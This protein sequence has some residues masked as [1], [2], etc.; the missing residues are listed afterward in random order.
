VRAQPTETSA[1]E[2]W[3]QE[4]HC[5]RPG[6]VSAASALHLV[7]ALGRVHTLGWSRSGIFWTLCYALLRST[8]CRAALAWARASNFNRMRPLNL[9]SVSNS[10]VKDGLKTKTA[11]LLKCAL[12]G[13]LLDQVMYLE[14]RTKF[15]AREGSGLSQTLVYVRNNCSRLI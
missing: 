12:G 8:G 3:R 5:R 7:R 2:L 11:S 9:P 13:K 10:A 1:G 4:Q 14:R 6:H 15:W